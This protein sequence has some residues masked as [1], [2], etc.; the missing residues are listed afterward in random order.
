M[1]H[2]VNSDSVDWISIVSK[3]LWS[4]DNKNQFEKKE[5]FQFFSIFA[6]YF[7]QFKCQSVIIMPNKVIFNYIP[8]E[9]FEMI[10]R[11]SLQSVSREIK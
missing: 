8:S 7:D 11:C 6:H 4:F 9:S 3:P 10:N 2:S 1:F 5:M